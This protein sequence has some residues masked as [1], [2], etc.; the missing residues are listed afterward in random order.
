MR[1]YETDN[2]E[3]MLLSTHLSG[4]SAGLSGMNRG[5]NNEIF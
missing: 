1:F 2:L 3:H 5:D 4:T